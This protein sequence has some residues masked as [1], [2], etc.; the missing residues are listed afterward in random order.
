MFLTLHNVAIIV[1]VMVVLSLLVISMLLNPNIVILL[2]LLI[3]YLILLLFFPDEVA[4][5]CKQLIPNSPNPAAVIIA[6]N[7]VQC[8]CPVQPYNCPEDAILVENRVDDCCVTYECTCPNISCPLLMESGLGVQPVP[9]YRG[10]KFPGRCCPDY[11]FEG[12]ES[13]RHVFS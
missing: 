5:V 7:E 1:S 2:S 11:S 4:T 10:N 8:D 12:E 13:E 3:A 6:C 9:N